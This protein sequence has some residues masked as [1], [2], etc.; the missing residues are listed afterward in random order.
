LRYLSRLHHIGLGAA[1]R[2]L[3]IH[4]LVANKNIRVVRDDG[5]LIRELTLDPTRAINP[6]AHRLNRL[7]SATMT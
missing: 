6:L 3:P 4:I 5:S 1:Y 2:G 7:E